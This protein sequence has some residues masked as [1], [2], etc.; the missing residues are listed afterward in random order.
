MYRIHLLDLLTEEEMEK[1]PK[2]LFEI[3]EDLPA[4]G[5]LVRSTVVKEE[6]IVPELLAISRAGVGVNTINVE[7]A[8]E[9][10]TIVMNT[11]G[12]NA[13]AV[14]ELVLCC[15]LL[16]VRPV[17]EASQMVQQLK[18]PDIL[19]QAEEKRGDYTGQELSGKTVGLLGLG[20]VGQAV[21]RS[22]YDLGM[23]VLGYA[24][25]DSHLDYVYQT[26]L[27]AVLSAADFVVV[28]LPLTKETMNLLDK[29][30]MEKM[31]KGAVLINVGRNGI[32]EKSAVLRLVEERK[33]ARYITDFPEEEFLGNE[34]IMMLP[35]IGGSTQE[36][37]ADGSRLAVQALED[38]LLFGT[39]TESVNYP[40]VRLLF[41]APFRITVFYQKKVN[42]L[43]EIFSILK[44]Q[45]VSIG[46]LTRSHK[47]GYQ[48]LLIDVENTDK[49]LLTQIKQ[50]IEQITG[51]KRVRLLKNP[52]S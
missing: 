7:K 52:Y 14:K 34:R 41:Q 15:L 42:I 23:N 5:I 47:E 3:T 24:Q 9:N 51:V 25:N 13:N 27:E 29:Q 28:M 22:C 36:A 48:Y 4:Q 26:N 18:G 46:D 8:T 33:L 43:A 44:N 50:Q 10:G 30:K 17:N 19:T 31:K 39:V 12:V 1:I 49:K 35:H 2:N 40:S 6:W 16:S 45:Q 38:Y 37:L 32:V 20:A 21:A 11:P